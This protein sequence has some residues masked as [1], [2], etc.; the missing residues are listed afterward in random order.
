MGEAQVLG[1]P[2]S[3]RGANGVELH[4]V[5]KLLDRW[6]ESLDGRNYSLSCGQSIAWR[7]NGQNVIRLFDELLVG[8]HE[9]DPSYMGRLMGC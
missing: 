5:K 2:S 9:F 4:I 7:H 6:L 8:S 3:R 1:H